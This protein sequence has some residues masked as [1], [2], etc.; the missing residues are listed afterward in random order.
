MEDLVISNKF[1]RDI[2]EDYF[3]FH[4]SATIEVLER[5]DDDVLELSIKN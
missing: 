3:G 4:L 2:M 5:I 1:S